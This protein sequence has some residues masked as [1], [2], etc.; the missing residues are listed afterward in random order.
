VET[1]CKRILEKGEHIMKKLKRM[2]VGIDIFAK[3]NNVL[4]RAFMVAKENKAELFIVHA[5]QTPWFSV[6]SYFGGKEISVDTEG[7]KKKIENNSRE[8]STT[9]SFTC[10]DR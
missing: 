9:K 7:I 8:S 2:I 5:V 1:V 6:P 10:F 3:S 4:K